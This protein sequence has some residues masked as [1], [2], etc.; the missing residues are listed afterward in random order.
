MSGAGGKTSKLATVGQGGPIDNV[1]YGDGAM[2]AVAVPFWDIET[3]FAEVDPLG[4]AGF[5]DDDVYLGI[6]GDTYADNP[7][8]RLSL[9]GLV[10]PGLWSCTATPA[11]LMDVQKPNGFDGAALVS[12]GYLNS[13][14]SITGRIWTPDQ[15]AEFQRVLPMIWRRPDKFAVT[16]Q[17]RQ[18]GQVQGQQKAISI[19]HPAVNSVGI[20]S[21][22]ITKLSPPEETGDRGVK[23]IKLTAMEYVPEPQ[24]KVPADK[25]AKGIADDRTVQA[26]KIA[27]KRAAEVANQNAAGNELTSR[28]PDVANMSVPPSIGQISA[29]PL[30]LPSALTSH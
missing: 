12:R 2:A 26:Q 13:G 20:T 6:T 27:Q 14:I 4:G 11:I 15:W 16:D 28:L 23:Q 3:T 24:R 25:K 30:P 18:R 19:V 7:W 22:I 17:K 8:D 1:G 10:M 29:N 9:A 5:P 21:I